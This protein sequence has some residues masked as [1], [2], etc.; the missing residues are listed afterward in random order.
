M[1]LPIGAS[2]E[3]NITLEYDP[4]F[5]GI[6]YTWEDLSPINFANAENILYWG[7]TAGKVLQS[8]G[9]TDNGTA[10]S[11]KAVSVPFGSRIGA[12]NVR[13]YKLWLVVN[14]PTGSSCS[15]YL[16]KSDQGDS[17]WTLVKTLTTKTSV[18]KQKI[19]IPVATVA[20]AGWIRFKIE[21]TGPVDLHEFDYVQREMPLH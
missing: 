7:D 15:V 20:N 17:D 2:T 3:P 5:S 21:G 14:V 16:S 4:E 10:I 9:T 13:W 1:T 6:W 11:W 18:Q 19:I 8:E 12:Q